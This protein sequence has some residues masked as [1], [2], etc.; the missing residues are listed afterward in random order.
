MITVFQNIK[1][2]QHRQS[3]DLLNNK[4]CENSTNTSNSKN[5]LHGMPTSNLIKVY[6]TGT[7][8]VSFKGQLEDDFFLAAQ[9]N[10]IKMQLKALSS[11][12]FDVQSIEQNTGN[13][14]LHTSLLNGN[15]QIINKAL[16]LLTNQNK[17]VREKVITQKNNSQ[18]V[19]YDFI[20]DPNI[21]N[22]LKTLLGSEL[23]NTQHQ[24]T[25]AQTGLS[26]FSNLAT[27]TKDDQIKLNKLPADAEIQNN[28]DTIDLFDLE[29]SPIIKAENKSS[30]IP[31]SQC[32]FAN[33]AGLDE[34]KDKFTKFIIEPFKKNQPITIN[35]FLIHGPSGNGKT[36]LVQALCN[37]LNEKP[38]LINDVLEL[39]QAMETAENKYKDTGKQTILFIDGIHSYL[40]K[41][42]DTRDNIK[43]NKMMQLIEGSASKGVIL[44]AATDRKYSI[45]P[46]AISPNRFDEHIEIYPPDLK[47]REKIIQLQIKDK[48]SINSSDINELTKMTSG[49]SSAAL[50]RIINKTYLVHKN[51]TLD[52][53]K[54]EIVNFAK[55]NNM[56]DI[57]ENGTTANYDTTFLRREKLKANDP[58]SL[59]E[60]AGMNEAKNTLYKTVV[61]SFDPERQKKYKENKIQIPNGILLYGPPGCGKTYIVKAVAAQAKLPLYQ[62]KLSDF[63]SKYANE[64]SNRLKQAFDQ[65]RT[66]YAK[67]GGAGKGEAS[68]LFFDEC[69]SFFRKVKGNENY[70]TDELN[71]LKEE[72]NN[73]GNDGIIIIAATNEIQD[74]NDAIIRDG[75]FDD[76]IFID[77]PDTEARFELIKFSLTDRIATKELLNDNEAVKKLVEMTDGL[78]SATITSIINKTV[79]NAID[80]DIEKITYENISTAIENKKAENKDLNEKGNYKR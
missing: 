74:L 29:E 43:T 23:P 72:M 3:K 65:L 70:R 7:T 18:Q 67:T 9:N 69:D 52:N 19:P 34:A 61:A 75:R 15:S 11:L 45:E 59:D 22:R 14:Y 28:E 79:K 71:T 5:L 60:V 68:I 8:D 66:K 64:T 35:G 58:K 1:N 76:K 53:F 78:S 42:N 80:N 37:E 57:S 49:L 10:D 20:S 17:A 63:G 47:A 73:A 36:F 30:I 2:I 12:N 44:I 25:D 39:E 77:F 21:I 33:I 13:N 16:L 62:I 41:I 32:I 48:S 55:D 4:Y 31:P 26:P 46:T 50:I 38:V 56:G 54:S 6:F 24:S 51:P 27:D 40:P